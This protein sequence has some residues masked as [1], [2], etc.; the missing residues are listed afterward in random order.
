M[1]LKRAVEMAGQAID[2]VSNLEHVDASLRRAALDKLAAK[3]KA[4]KADVQ[5]RLDAKLAD[6]DA[7]AK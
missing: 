5:A 7:P 2:L 1:D 3:A 4:A 6:L